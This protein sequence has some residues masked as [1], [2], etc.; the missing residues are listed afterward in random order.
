MII[1]L[2]IPLL[3][4]FTIASQFACTQV[5]IIMAQIATYLVIFRDSFRSLHFALN[6]IMINDRV[7]LLVTAFNKW[8]INLDKFTRLATSHLWLVARHLILILIRPIICL[9]CL[10]SFSHT[11]SST[12]IHVSGLQPLIPTSDINSFTHAFHTDLTFLVSAAKPTLKISVVFSAPY[13]IG[14]LP[15]TFSC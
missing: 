6:I 10:I 9:V 4:P 15:E 14:N 3:S 7:M 11:I 12:W 1:A 13:D 5:Y 2:C 8:C